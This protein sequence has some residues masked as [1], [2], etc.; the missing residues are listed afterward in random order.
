MGV[1]GIRSLYHE[2]S[3]ADHL[4]RT[5]LVQLLDENPGEWGRYVVG[6]TGTYAMVLC[7][8]L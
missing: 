8:T 1:N 7:T 5:K 6:S 4:I 3:I 2:N